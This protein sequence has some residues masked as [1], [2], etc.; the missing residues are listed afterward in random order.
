[1]IDSSA[2]DAYRPYIIKHLVENINTVIADSPVQRLALTLA[3]CRSDPTAAIMDTTA[4]S[5][6]KGM[7]LSEWA[8]KFP[9]I[10]SF[11]MDLFAYPAIAMESKMTASLYD[12]WQKKSGMVSSTIINEHD[13][14]ILLDYNTHSPGFNHC[15]G[16]ALHSCHF[17]SL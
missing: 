17:P 4:E 1:M 8:T 16:S 5:A 11:M 6:S 12:I 3:I 13:I 2:Y 7:S 15:L 10:R 9:Y 14:N